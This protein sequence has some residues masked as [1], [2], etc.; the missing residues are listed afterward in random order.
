MNKLKKLSKKLVRAGVIGALLIAVMLA[1]YIG[2]TVFSSG[3]QKEK[4]DVENKYKSDKSLEEDLK[5]QLTNSD[6]AGKRFVVL[7][8]K[9]RTD[10]YD[11]SSETLIE[12]LK[13]AKLRY[14]FEQFNLSRPQKGTPSDKDQLKNLS[15]YDIS[16]RPLQFKITATSD[17]H[18]FSFIDDL[19]ADIPGILRIDGISFKRSAD[20]SDSTISQLSNGA[21]VMTVE[22][23][24]DLTWVTVAAK[25]SI[26]T[27]ATAAGSA[28]ATPHASGA[29]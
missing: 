11:G 26:K 28:G 29:K 19:M 21:K 5:R 4:Q 24:V 6:E 20:L 2:A 7:Q 27:P 3:S 14:K 1:L 10:H 18:V 23:T 15:N 22:A 16:T 12:Y 9:R 13:Q 25:E 17:L 8:E